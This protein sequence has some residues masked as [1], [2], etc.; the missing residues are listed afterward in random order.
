ME[1]FQKK[2]QAH[3]EAMEKLMKDSESMQKW[4]D[5]NNLNLCSI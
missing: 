2:D 1:M 5:E 3:L 4:Q